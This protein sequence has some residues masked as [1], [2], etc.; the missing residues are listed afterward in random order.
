[1]PLTDAENNDR[2]FIE[3]CKLHPIK[4]SETFLN[5]R[6][7]SLQERI[8][9]TN[10]AMNEGKVLPVNDTTVLQTDNTTSTAVVNRQI[11]RDEYFDEIFS[12]KNREPIQVVTEKYK[13]LNINEVSRGLSG[14]VTFTSVIPPKLTRLNA[15][16]GKYELDGSLTTVANTSNVANYDLRST[17]LSQRT[18]GNF[19]LTQSYRPKS[20]SSDK[21]LIGGY[22]QMDFGKQ[23]EQRGL[24]VMFKLTIGGGKTTFGLGPVY[25]QFSGGISVTRQKGEAL[26][27][28]KPLNAS[29]VTLVF[30]K[31]NT[32]ESNLQN[33]TTTN[34]QSK[35]R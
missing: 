34:Q 22:A 13:K 15:I 3:N 14:D 6:V 10:A 32:Q 9:A 2:L 29:D 7:S 1:M 23:A 28:P 20:T 11:T 8:N 12:A 35:I 16:T 31:T 17:Q 25:N 5:L 33:T 27:L 30:T 4:V 19:I 24:G 21:N 18:D 26:P